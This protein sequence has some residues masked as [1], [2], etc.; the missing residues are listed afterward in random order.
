MCIRDRSGIYP[1]D[2]CSELVNDSNDDVNC[3]PEDSDKLVNKCTVFRDEI[4]NCVGNVLSDSGEQISL[5]SENFINKNM[6]QF[7]KVPILPINNTVIKTATEYQQ[8]VNKQAYLNIV[9]Q[10]TQLEVWKCLY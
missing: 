6:A 10:G 8:T 4:N 3:I 1:S 5:I 9:S 7:K 2:I